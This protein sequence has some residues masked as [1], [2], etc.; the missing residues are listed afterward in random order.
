[1]PAP[2]EEEMKRQMTSAC[3]LPESEAARYVGI[4]RSFLRHSRMDQ[5][6][7]PGPAFVRI[8][9]KILY[10]IEDLDAWLLAHR[11]EPCGIVEDV[12]HVRR[13]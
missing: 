11:V 12:E 9:R 13:A 3:T 4:S 2:A 10:R 1:M 7:T 5:T 8:G 6:P